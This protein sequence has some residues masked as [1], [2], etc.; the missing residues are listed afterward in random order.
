[1]KSA[2]AVAPLLRPT[3]AGVFLEVAA[4]PLHKGSPPLKVIKGVDTGELVPI[5]ELPGY[6]V[7]RSGR[8]FC[9]RELATWISHG[10]V[11]TRVG[12][13]P[14]PKQPNVH[15]LL[16]IT[17]LKRERGKTLV[18]HLDGNKRN[19]NLENLAWGTEAENSEDMIRHGRSRRGTKSCTNILTEKEVLE[20]RQRYKDGESLKD[21]ASE[22]GVHQAT[23]HA[24][25]CRRSW[26]WLK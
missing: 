17:F 7:T 11:R 18:R 9:L 22:Y 24:I 13:K 23:I 1:V 26:A 4:M 25:H 19:N 16:A 15:R 5:P 8:V 3:A 12:S 6:Y 2:R 20:I 10:Y 14:N 21:L